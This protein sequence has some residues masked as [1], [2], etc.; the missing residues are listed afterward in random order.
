MEMNENDKLIEQLQTEVEKLYK[1]LNKR[2]S[3]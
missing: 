3:K 1:E 2:K